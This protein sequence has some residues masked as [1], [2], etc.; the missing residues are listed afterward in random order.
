MAE[1][2]APLMGTPSGI[3]QQHR[4]LD[5]KSSAKVLGLTPWWVRRLIA[6]GELRA[7]NVGGQDKAA[8]WRVDPADLD[9]W[10]RQRETQPGIAEVACP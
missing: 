3:T 8:R 4:L 6:R 7:I 10:M 5:V 1:D 2:T 9:A